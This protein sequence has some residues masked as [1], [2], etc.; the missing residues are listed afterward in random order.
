MIIAIDY[1]T[2][3]IGLAISDETNVLAGHL[4][5][6]IVKNKKEAIE[7]LTQII[8]SF[9]MVDE[10]VFGLPLGID[11][12]PTKMSNEIKKFV[13]ELKPHINKELTIA[14]TNE[15]LSSKQAEKG[16]SKKFKKQKSHS[17]AARIFLQEYLDHRNG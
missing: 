3:N 13:E 4:P 10:V 7:G 15:V 5:H 1:G 11:F 8:N 16:R 12:K 2:K 9:P 14:F 17:E 6:L